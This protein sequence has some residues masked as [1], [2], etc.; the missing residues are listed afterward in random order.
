[1]Y[2]EQKPLF[3]LTIG[4]FIELTKSLVNEAIKEIS[5]QKHATE[6]ISGND[7]NFNIMELAGFLRCSKVSVHNYKKKGLPFYRVGR[8][9]LFKKLEVLEFMKKLKGKQIK[10]SK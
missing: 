6:A 5:E 10:A 4:E 3:T 9:I 8:K 1:M 2:P 7:E